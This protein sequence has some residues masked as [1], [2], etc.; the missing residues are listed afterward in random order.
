[1]NPSAVASRPNTNPQEE[2]TIDKVMIALGVIMGEQNIEHDELDEA[3]LLSRKTVFAA[4][5]LM[6]TRIESGAMH[7]LSEFLDPASANHLNS[8][9]LTALGSLREVKSW[10]WVDSVPE[11]DKARLRI[12]KVAASNLAHLIAPQE[13][14]RAYNKVSQ[15]V[16]EIGNHGRVSLTNALDVSAA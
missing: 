10:D 16:E 6:K 2:L 5:S 8:I 9:L 13:L 7:S 14:M 4:L 3:K 1:M 12:L 15:E 11:Q